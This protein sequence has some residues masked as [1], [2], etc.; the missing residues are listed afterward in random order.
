[1]VAR[2]NA[3]CLAC[4]FSVEALVAAMYLG[5]F[6]FCTTHMLRVS[7]VASEAV[8]ERHLTLVEPR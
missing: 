3:A 1:M 8:G 5:A 6:Q 7:A 4:E 2:P